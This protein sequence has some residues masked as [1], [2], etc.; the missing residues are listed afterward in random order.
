[1]ITGTTPV[2]TFNLLV[3]MS[4]VK[5]IKII[6]H[7]L[8]SKVL[9]KYTKD[10][11]IEGTTVKVP[12]TQEETFLFKEKVVTIVIR[13]LTKS[14]DALVSKPITIDVTS[15]LDDEVLK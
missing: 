2:H 8:G 5:E 4:L 10:C 9:E 14:G 12:L 7:Q 3:D 13:I 6:Y 1:M 15:C 11:I